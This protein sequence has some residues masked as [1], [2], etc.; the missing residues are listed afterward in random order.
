M[1]DNHRVNND[2]IATLRRNGSSFGL[3]YK[4]SIKIQTNKTQD[5]KNLIKT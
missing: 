3:L 1:G 5:L 2:Y 4:D